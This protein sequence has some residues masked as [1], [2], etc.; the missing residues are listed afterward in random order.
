MICMNNFPV[1]IVGNNNTVANML[2]E[3]AVT[4]TPLVIAAASIVFQDDTLWNKT[5]LGPVN[6]LQNGVDIL[7]E[8][9]FTLLK[10]RFPSCQKNASFFLQSK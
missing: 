10:M 9:L 2:I 4:I 8:D 5:N 6:S 3:E 1:N 7:K